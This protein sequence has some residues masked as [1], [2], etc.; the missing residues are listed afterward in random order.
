MIRALTQLRRRDTVASLLNKVISRQPNWWR[1][2]IDLE[3][4]MRAWEAN[5]PREKVLRLYE[6]LNQLG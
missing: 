3:D 2:L 6:F 4:A 1:D 5:T